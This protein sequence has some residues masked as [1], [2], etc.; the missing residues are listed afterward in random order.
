MELSDKKRKV[1]IYKYIVEPGETKHVR[2]LD[3]TGIFQQYGIDFEEF[4][5]G[6]GNFT[7][8]IVEMPD[9]SVRSVPLQLII[10]VS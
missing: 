1:N 4:D 5:S 9:G 6:P 2:K 8:A 3:G 10:F 7:V